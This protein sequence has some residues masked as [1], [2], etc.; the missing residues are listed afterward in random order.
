MREGRTL[1]AG[2]KV[3]AQAHGKAL[4][5]AHLGQKPLEQGLNILG[6]HIDSPRLDLKQNPLYE[7]NGFTLFDTHYYGGI[8][9][10][11]WVTLPLALHGVI[12][13]KDGTVVDVQVG[14]DP[15]DPVFCVTDLLVHLAGK[16]MAKKANEVVEGEDLDILMGNRP[17]TCG[18]GSLDGTQSLGSPGSHGRSAG[19][20][21][22]CGTRLVGA[23]E[24]LAAVSEMHGVPTYMWHL[25]GE[26]VFILFRHLGYHA[27]QHCQ[28]AGVVGR[29]FVVLARRAFDAFFEQEV[30]SQADAEERHAGGYALADGVHLAELAHGGG[31]VG[32]RANAGQ[33]DG[34]GFGDGGGI[35]RDEHLGARRDQTALDAFEV[36]LMIVDHGDHS[37]PFVEGSASP[38]RGSS[39][40]AW[41]K[42]RAAALNDASTIWCAFSPAR[43]R[44][45]SVSPAFAAKAMKNSLASDASNVPSM[46]QGTSTAQCSWP[47]PDMSTAASTRASSMGSESDPNRAMPRFG[48][49]QHDARVLHGV[50][51]VHL[52]IAFCAH[53]EVDQAMPSEGRQHMVEERHAR[54]DVGRTRAVEVHRD[55]DV[56]LVRR[57]D[58]FGGSLV[59]GWPF[60]IAGPATSARVSVVPEIVGRARTKRAPKE[61][62]VGDTS[63]R[64]SSTSPRD[65]APREA[66]PYGD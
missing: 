10:Y 22:S 54:L 46:T 20:S 51:R 43:L 19:L 24:P 8:K 25:V 57:A 14:D 41:R 65:R 56:R 26:G 35:A 11:Q 5:L 61:V 21:G 55:A 12:A 27:R 16:Q 7:S 39:S 17:L 38:M 28:A 40:T 53:V 4:I 47:R 52:D 31:R 63:V 66:A 29:G 2:D 37:A 30:H 3:W 23:A 1:K 48:L 62:P 60:F 49:A 15:D 58:D 33:H 34:I 18:G 6:A 45:C 59:H 42:A 44:T 32:E 9:N 13:K 50:V 36:A 64:E